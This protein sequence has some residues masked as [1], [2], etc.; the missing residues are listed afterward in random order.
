[1]VSEGCLK[2]AEVECLIKDVKNLLGGG[3]RKIEIT[4]DA[5]CSLLNIAVEDMTMYLQNW[6]INEKWSNLIG[7]NINTTDLCAALSTHS[8][9]HELDF[10]IAYSKQVGFQSRGN[11]IMKKDY[12][13]LVD[14]QQVYE[15][16]AHR[17]IN[18]VLWQTPSDI[19]FAVHQTVGYQHQLGYGENGSYVNSHF[20]TQAFNGA[21]YIAPAFDIMLRGADISLKHRIRQSD[22]TYSITAGENGTK[23]LHLYSIPNSG[24]TIG[25]RKNLYKCKVWYFYYDTADMTA[26]EKNKCL[27]D[28]KD[29]IKYP[30]E[31]SLGEL[32]YCD[33]NLPSKVWIRRYLSALAKE[34]LGRVRSK[35]SGSLKIPNAEVTMDGETLLAEAK[36][37][38]AALIVELQLRL[39]LL[40]SDKQMERKANEATNLNTLL[41]Y[42]PPRGGSIFVI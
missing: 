33:L 24:N 25:A 6:V 29:I 21:Y 4:E 42:M 34:T 37:E 41:K 38:K 13:E 16:P 8:L 1:M 3:L 35:F 20:G 10:T 27:D 15:I 19:D 28:C 32:S 22:L 11:Y 17:L 14:G 12:V 23:L 30:T 39:E 31:V 36:E 40:Q 9:D 5:F 26:A 7:K 18:K 2:S